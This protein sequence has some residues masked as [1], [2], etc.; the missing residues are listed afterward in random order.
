MIILNILRYL[1]FVTLLLPVLTMRSAH[2]EELNVLLGG[3]DDNRYLAL[4]YQT[5]ALW[6]GELVSHPLDLSL[7]FSLGMVHITSSQSNRTTW[8][9]GA[10]PVAHWWLSQNI[11][12]ELGV[13]TNIFSDTHLGD[14]DISTAFQFGSSIGLIYR[15]KETPWQFGARLT[16]YSNAGIKEPNPGQN[17]VQL[18][19]SYVFP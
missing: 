12:V 1:V 7:E 6:Q 16:H 14:K 13:G 17:Y 19:A 4:G 10:S 5:S 15:E 11:A 2:A 18:R 8:H 3:D 9:L